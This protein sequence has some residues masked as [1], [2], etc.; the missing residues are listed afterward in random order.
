[1][2]FS[3]RSFVACLSFLAAAGSCMASDASAPLTAA[4]VAAPSRQLTFA[5]LMPPEDS[6]VHAAARIIGNGL[7]AANQ[8]SARPANIL[9]IEAQKG[10][11][12]EEQLQAAAL[13]GAD[14]VIGPIERGAV[15]RLTEL[16]SLPL[17]VVALN[18]AEG[19][20][21]QYPPKLVILSISTEAEAEWIARLAIRALPAQTE[22][23][24]LPKV[25]VIAGSAPWETRIAEAY[26]RTLAHAGIQYEIQRLDPE[27]LSELQTHFEPVLNEED[28]QKLKALAHEQLAK[29]ES[30][31]ERK[32]ISRSIAN[33]RRTKIATAEPPFQAA[34]FALS[35][36]EASLVRNRLPLRMRVWSTSATNPGDPATSSTATT[37]AYDLE[38]LVFSECPLVVRYDAQSFEARFETAMPYSL[39]AK[40]L[41]ALGADAR[42]IAAQ[43]S[44]LRT[45][46]QYHGETGSLELNRLKS[47]VITREP[48]S[49]IVRSGRLVEVPQEVV[50]KTE[51]PNI[52]PPPDPASMTFVPVKEVEHDVRRESVKGIVISDPGPGPAPT[53]MLQ[54]TMPARTPSSEAPAAPSL[55]GVPLSGETITPSEMP[56][57]PQL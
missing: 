47:P 50:A 26:A 13:A 27:K 32:R 10:S 5:L 36:Q 55:G 37:L 15:T 23:G 17:P 44:Q 41:F 30:E 24:T 18:S 16:P 28:E 39:S 53:P 9:V 46:I 54:K 2:P 20:R 48:Q 49:V 12:I 35:A 25:A 40:R 31:S 3:R 56:R 51:L 38:K 43:W 45:Q 4:E 19:S 22:A 33:M 42:E 14:A 6:P 21:S 34:L 1:M 11:S 8:T 7:L 52:E 29:A 57:T